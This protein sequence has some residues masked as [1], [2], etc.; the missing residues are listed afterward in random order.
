MINVSHREHKILYESGTILHDM[1][2]MLSIVKKLNNISVI[3]HM[4]CLESYVT[5]V[6]YFIHYMVCK[7]KSYVSFII[8]ST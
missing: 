2:N 1:M 8:P 4:V 6:E 3:Y 5:K 7:K